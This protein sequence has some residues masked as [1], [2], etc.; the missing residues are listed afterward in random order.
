MAIRRQS[1][2]SYFGLHLPQA[3]LDFVDVDVRRDT[4]VFVDPAAL[5]IVQSEWSA[6][7]RSLIQNYFHHV[8]D[9]IRSGDEAG[10]RTLLAAL[11]EPNETHLGLSRARAQ[12]HGMGEGLANRVTSALLESPAVQSGLLLDLQDTALM[13]EGIDR[14]MISDITTNLLREPLIRY[15]QEV[16]DVY[17]IPMEL[18]D[19]GPLWQPKTRSWT[20]RFE[21]LPK[22]PAGRLLLVPKALVRVHMTYQA[23]EYYRHYLLTHMQGVHLS[24]NTSLVTVLKDGR[25]KVYK[26]DLEREYGTG[27]RATVALTTAN[28]QV[29]DQYRASKQR[30]VAPL[31]S[32]REL[33]ATVRSEEPDWDAL[34]KAVAK[35][36]RGSAGA[37]SYHKAVKELLAALFYPS[38]A[39]PVIEAEIH[40]G[41]KRIDIQFT[42]QAQAGF[43]AHVRDNYIA[44]FIFVE[45]KNYTG[46]PA[47]PELDQLSGR[48]SNR[49]GRVGFLCCRT[50]KNKELF[51]ARC[52]QTADDDR[53]YVLALDDRDLKHLVADRKVADLPRDAEALLRERLEKLVM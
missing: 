6:E 24:A 16:C 48:F 50:L 34:L 4:R 22:G 19:S 42:N 12:G 26:T 41:R 7:C 27:K 43:F 25:R 33:N 11:R 13:V 52:R 49:R 53:G 2:S 28:P 31:M 8:L 17:G 10:A 14:D 18:L 44:P 35:V 29:L 45:C 30:D 3:A 23:G 51:L 36:P 21:L 37:T 1:V 47:N 46:D 20:S 15:T 32:E 9:K 40:S 5:L 38:L 39:F